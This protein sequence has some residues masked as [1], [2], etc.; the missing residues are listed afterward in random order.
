MSFF[1]SS[2]ILIVACV[3]SLFGQPANI[4]VSAP[5]A[6]NLIVATK[7]AHPELQKLGL[8]AIPPG[9]RD[10]FIIANGI[11][12]KI[13][14]KSSTADLTV[15]DSGK[16]SVKNNDA[17]KFFDLGLPVNDAMGRP[18][19]MCVMEIPYAFAKDASDVVKQRAAYEMSCSAT[20]RVMVSFSKRGFRCG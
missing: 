7:A 3:S 6:Q 13:G 10:Y 2:R 19:G 16:P 11:P 14:K 5:Y 1:S 4:S 17:G 12:T 15:I 18:I 8:H 9:Q 20:S